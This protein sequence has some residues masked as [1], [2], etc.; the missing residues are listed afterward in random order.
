MAPD[1]PPDPIRVA[2]GITALLDRLGVPYVA[3]GSIASS[4]HGQPRSTDGI[5]LVADLQPSRIPAFLQALEGEYQVSSAT[6]L[7]VGSCLTRRGG[8]LSRHFGGPVRGTGEGPLKYWDAS[9][10]VPLL[11]EEAR[12][13][14]A[15]ERLAADPEI[16]TW[17]STR[18]E[19]RSALSR[20]LHRERLNAQRST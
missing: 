14:D 12:S 1:L 10:V 17:W 3:V 11:L 7:P 5:D 9:A 6:D 18:V 8:S 15:R 20:L 16:V 4:V 19:C 2:L 13:R